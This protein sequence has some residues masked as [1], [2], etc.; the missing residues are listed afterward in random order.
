MVISNAYVQ[1][2]RYSGNV[3]LTYSHEMACLRI[4]QCPVFRASLDNAAEFIIY[5]QSI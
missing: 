2:T 5:R 3:G 4:L 1:P